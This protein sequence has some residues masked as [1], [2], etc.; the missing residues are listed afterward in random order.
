MAYRVP[1]QLYQNEYGLKSSVFRNIMPCN[2]VKVT[3][4]AASIGVLATCFM[5]VDSHQTAGTLHSQHW[6]PQSQQRIY[7]QFQINAEQKNLPEE[8]SEAQTV[9]CP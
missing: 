6:E 1:D 5:L 7:F 2:L 3:W 9:V 4:Q 8:I